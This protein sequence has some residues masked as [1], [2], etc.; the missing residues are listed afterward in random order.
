M[1]LETVSLDLKNTGKHKSSVKK[2][3][4]MTTIK[5]LMGFQAGSAPTSHG[6]RLGEGGTWTAGWLSCLARGQEWCLQGRTWSFMKKLG[7]YQL[8]FWS[9]VVTIVCAIQCFPVRAEGEDGS[10]SV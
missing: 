1:G 5:A 4:G 10:H 8:Y 3:L 9:S 2:A 6:D 7:V